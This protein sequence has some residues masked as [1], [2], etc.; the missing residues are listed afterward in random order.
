VIVRWALGLALLATA[1]VVPGCRRH[2]SNPEDAFRRLAEAVTRQDGKALFEALDQRTRWAWMTVQK[3]H[4]EAYD[5]VLSNY[6]EGEL[7]TRSQRRFERAAELGSGRDLFAEEGAPALLASLRLVLASAPT[8]TPTFTRSPDGETATATLP[9][10]SLSFRHG[11]DDSWGYDGAWP[12]AEDRQ[13]RALSDVDMA[14]ASASD[15]ERAAG[16]R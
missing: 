9:Q 5:I 6:P 7:R 2:A 1:A 11:P 12:D 10:T 8:P 15:F 16:R 4:R 14:R 3:S 13:K